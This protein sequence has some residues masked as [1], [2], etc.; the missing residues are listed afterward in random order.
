MTDYELALTIP[1]PKPKRFDRG[2]QPVK[3]FFTARIDGKPISR[4]SK[5]WAEFHKQAYGE[6]IDR[7]AIS[8]RV[9][10][11]WD[12]EIACLARKGESEVQ[13]MERLGKINTTR[14]DP[15]AKTSIEQGFFSRSLV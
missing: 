9:K 12:Q 15:D 8:S 3:L 10:K 5:W 2:G 1:E 11:G 13:A 4:S 14:I 6:I 7:C